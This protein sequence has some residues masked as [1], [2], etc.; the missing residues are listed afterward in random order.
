MGLLVMMVSIG[1]RSRSVTRKLLLILILLSGFLASL[2]A[3]A[4]QGSYTRKS[5]TALDSVLVFPQA[6]PI[7]RRS[8]AFDLDR[9]KKFL[10]HHI[11]M[12]RF[13]FNEIPEHLQREFIRETDRYWDLDLS[14]LTNILE[15]T[16]V[17]SILDILNDPEIQKARAMQFKDEASLTSFAAT[18]AKS[19]GLTETEL[20]TLF[21]SAYIY[22]PFISSAFVQKSDEGFDTVHLTGGIIW[23]KIDVDTSGKSSLRQLMVATTWSM[24]FI[25]YDRIDHVF[26][27]DGEAWYADPLEYAVNDA[28]L[29]FAKNL[30]VK[31]REIPDF[32]LQAQITESDGRKFAFPL[33][34]NEGVRLDDGFDIVEYREQKDGTVLPVNKGYMRVTRTG[35]NAYDPTDPSYGV[36]LLGTRASIGDVVMEHPRLGIDLGL[37]MGITT[38]S[39]ILPEH[40]AVTIG[41]VDYP[42]LESSADSQLTLS[43]LFSYNLAPIFNISQLFVNLDVGLG[44]PLADAKDS[45]SLSVLS[46]YVGISKRY[47]RRLLVGGSVAMGVDMLHIADSSSGW[48]TTI[49]HLAF[50]V[51]ASVE[52]LY[53]LSPDWHVTLAAHHKVGFAPFDS[54]VTVGNTDWPFLKDTS[55]VRLGGTTVSVGITY[56]LGSLPFNLFGFL[57][58]LKQF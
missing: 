5:V 26:I 50:G 17:E 39:T 48:N 47:G 41:S 25:D 7:V 38:G 20:L 27:F 42:A 28:M 30:A 36:Q 9:F 34:R 58:P 55:D 23:W 6:S 24:G 14:T 52:A 4:V 46:P 37:T 22:L 2:S 53:M 16:V 33:G 21:N 51:K 31:T 44:L 29:A 40:T 12:P 13:D 18:K 54:R 3:T 10:T 56:S 49:E 43:A 57:D 1:T 19:M 35:N 45:A 15:N 8:W 11:E 32:K